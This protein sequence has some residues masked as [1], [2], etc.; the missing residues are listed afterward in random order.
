MTTKLVL[1]TSIEHGF[2]QIFIAIFFNATI[3]RFARDLAWLQL[4]AV[5]AGGEIL[6]TFRS[7]E[8]TIGEVGPI[9]NINNVYG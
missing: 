6:G 8:S 1:N 7:V 5:L 3:D 4:T 2:A 9:T